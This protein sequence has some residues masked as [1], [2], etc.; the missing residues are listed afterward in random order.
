MKGDTGLKGGMSDI[1]VLEDMKNKIGE[2]DCEKD[3]G[4]ECTVVDSDDK[5]CALEEALGP[6]AKVAKTRG[7]AVTLPTRC[8]KKRTVTPVTLQM[9]V[10]FRHPTKGNCSVTCFV[11]GGLWVRME[12]MPWLLGY[13]HEQMESVGVRGLGDVG[14]ECE[15]SVVGADSAVAESKPSSVRWDFTAKAWVG[16]VSSGRN[17][18][19]QATCNMKDFTKKK[20]E[21]AVAAAGIGKSWAQ[22][23]DKDRRQCA[24]VYLQLQVTRHEEGALQPERRQG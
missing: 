2:G 22:A 5:M 1:T 10:S 4:E 21:E 17:A 3:T 20:Y 16:T 11:K 24:K 14:V 12:D 19:K 23:S 7:D 9:P 6:P 15:M 18:G 8:H 13:M